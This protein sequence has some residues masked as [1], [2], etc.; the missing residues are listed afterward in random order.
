MTNEITKTDKATKVMSLLEKMKPQMALALPKHMNADRIARIALTE[1]RKNPQLQQCD[2]ASFA[3]AIMLSAQLGLEV[4]SLGHAY[5]I[6]FKS[7]CTF[8]LGYRGMV[9]LARRSGQIVSLSAHVVYENDK[10]EYSYGLEDKLIHNPCLGEPGK[11][12]AAYAVAKLKDGGHQF[13]VMS[14]AEVDKIRD[15]SRAKGSIPWTQHYNEMAKKT[16]IRRLFKY[17]PVSIEMQRAIAY[18]DR[19]EAK[20]VH[21][22]DMLKEISSEQGIQLPAELLG[23]KVP[24]ADDN[25]ANLIA[26][27]NENANVV[28]EFFDDTPVT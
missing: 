20:G 11:M 1:F 23:H 18:D 10:F 24:S 9:E 25:L 7:E 12:I 13:E 2:E 5:L 15:T 21:T 19:N 27:K 3:A 16:V 6:P 28:E 26:Q 8:M 4:G 17:L 14:K 22:I